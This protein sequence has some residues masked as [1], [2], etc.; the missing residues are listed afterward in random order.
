MNGSHVPQN[1][2]P[3]VPP[4]QEP[5]ASLEKMYM[6]AYLQSKGYTLH[7]ICDL[8]EGEAK[9][10]MTEASA[11]ASVKLTEVEARAHFVEEIHGA[12]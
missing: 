8:P 1:T 2:E 11:Y 3:C 10:L 9:R 6:E 7:G 4:M 12:S 5:E